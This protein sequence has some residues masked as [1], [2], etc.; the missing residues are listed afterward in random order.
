MEE[1]STVRRLESNW[2]L[3]LMDGV[4]QLRKWTIP[5]LPLQNASK[6]SDDILRFE[7]VIAKEFIKNELI[8]CVILS[9]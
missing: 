8:R 1:E 5:L 7:R 2:K 4:H 9:S 6:T 3:S